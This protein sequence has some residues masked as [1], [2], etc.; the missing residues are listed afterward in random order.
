M[1]NGASNHPDNFA[2][3]VVNI[4]LAEANGGLPFETAK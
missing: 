1:G 4:L 3:F 2:A